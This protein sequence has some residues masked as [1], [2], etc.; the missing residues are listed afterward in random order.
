MP[1]GQEV[2]GEESGDS[3]EPRKEQSASFEPR[4][5]A[6]ITRG[7]PLPRDASSRLSRV[8]ASSHGPGGF[9]LALW[10]GSGS[11]ARRLPPALPPCPGRSASGRARRA[12]RRRRAA[13][14][15]RR[16]GSC[17]RRGARWRRPRPKRG[18]CA[19]ARP[20]CGGA[21]RRP[22]RRCS[23]AWGASASSRR[24]RA[25]CPACSAGCGCWRASC[26]A[27]G[28]RG[29]WGWGSPPVLRAFLFP[30]RSHGSLL[31]TCSWIH[32]SIHPW[33]GSPI[34]SLHLPSH[35]MGR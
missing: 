6:S 34:K 14:P 28:E 26:G 29:G 19:G 12:P 13:S 18:G 35:A 30:T 10:A 8:R 4:S 32:S 21:R 3:L 20:R 33:S 2:G 24:W 25:R 16:R 27:T 7:H 5:P 9:A 23:A 1:Q 17:G 11:R 15:R 22:G 31:F